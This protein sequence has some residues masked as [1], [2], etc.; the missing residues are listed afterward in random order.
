MFVCF[1]QND[2]YFMILSSLVHLIFTL[3]VKQVL[4]FKYPYHSIDTAIS[5][6]TGHLKGNFYWL[7][8][9]YTLNMEHYSELKFYEQEHSWHTVRYCSSLCVEN[10]NKPWMS[11]L[12]LLVLADIQVHSLL[13]MKQECLKVSCDDQCNCY[14]IVN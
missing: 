2:V 6:K 9:K 10:M 4:M 1:P 5:I 14:L 8:K 7:N 13:S 3:H 11:L 12:E